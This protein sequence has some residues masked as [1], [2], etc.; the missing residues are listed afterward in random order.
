MSGAFQARTHQYLRL[1]APLITMSE[2]PSPFPAE[3][4]MAPDWPQFGQYFT[5]LE[6]ASTTYRYFRKVFDY[7]HYRLRNTTDVPT[8]QDLNMMYKSKK[9]I[10]RLSIFETLR[11]EQSD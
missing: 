10:D 7:R 4:F 8:E 1:S 3:V 5:S 11:W 2:I 6:P 9:N